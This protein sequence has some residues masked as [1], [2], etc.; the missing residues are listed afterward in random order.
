MSCRSLMLFSSFRISSC[1]VSISF[2]A[3]FVA[4]ASIRIWEPRHRHISCFIIGFYFCISVAYFASNNL[5]GSPHKAGQAFLALGSCSV[6]ITGSI[7]GQR[8]YSGLQTHDFLLSAHPVNRPGQAVEEVTT[9]QI[10]F[11]I[12][13]KSFFFCPMAMITTLFAINLH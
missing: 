6:S 3:C 2:R 1:R 12:R 5:R 11:Y 7:Q 13:N 9:E 10:I 4:L 8:D